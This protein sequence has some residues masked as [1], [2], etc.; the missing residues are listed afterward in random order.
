MKLWYSTCTC[1]TPVR[2]A[3]E[4]AGARYEA[5]EVSWSKGQ[6][7]AELEALN[8]LGAVPVLQLDDGRVLTQSVAILEHV[9]DTHPSALLLAAPGT[10]ERAQTLGWTA[11]AAADLLRSFGPLSRADDMTTSEAARAE[12]RA[13]GLAQVAPLLAH[14]DRS[15]R[16][17]DFVVGDRFTIADGYLFFLVRLA[18]WLDVPLDGYAELDRYARKIAA[19]PAVHRVLELEDL[20][21]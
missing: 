20:L 19:R 7:V 14:L 21:D 4:E 15:L 16:G 13:F 2:F 5:V 12:V 3:L 1:S 18:G 17:R 8:P 6:R 9:A 11:F 10:V